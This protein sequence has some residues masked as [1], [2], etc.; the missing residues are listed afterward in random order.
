MAKIRR[1]DQGLRSNNRFVSDLKNKRDRETD[2]R[3][4]EK[5]CC[6][7][8]LFFV[9]LFSVIAIAHPLWR[10]FLLH[11]SH[12]MSSRFRCFMNIEI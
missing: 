9:D 11:D 3:Q 5:Y 2:Y 6:C 10:I 1:R 12:K 8:F 4:S 7:E